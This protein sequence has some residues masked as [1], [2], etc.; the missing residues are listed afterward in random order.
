ML[1]FLL[2]AQAE[3]TGAPSCTC[4]A[5][6]SHG[7]D[8]V[9][10]HLQLCT[11]GDTVAGTLDWVGSRSGTNTRALSGTLTPSGYLL[12]DDAITAQ[13]PN[14]PWVFC[15]VDRYDLRLTPDGGLQGTYRSDSCRDTATMQ[16]EPAPCA[17]RGDA[18]ARPG[19]GWRR[20]AAPPHTWQLGAVRFGLPLGPDWQP[21]EVPAVRDGAPWAGVSCRVA[22]FATGPEL[23]VDVREVDV[24]DGEGTCALP[25]GGDPVVVPVA[26]VTVP[27]RPA[28][29]DGRSARRS[30]R[31]PPAGA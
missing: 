18:D 12:R 4:F 29:P 7:N 27:S 17:R 22:T 31:P 1:F 2:A 11:A 14:P 26:V 30:G 20:P 24:A 3:T 21:S 23:V 28:G 10:T 15:R 13:A 5:G 16:L 9:R 19:R 8:E 25:T 6:A